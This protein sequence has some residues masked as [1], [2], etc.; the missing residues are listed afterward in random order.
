MRTHIVRLRAVLLGGSVVL[1][2]GFLLWKTRT[3]DTDAHGRFTDDLRQLKQ[4]D[5]NLN[6]DLLKI[7][8]GLLANYDSITDTLDKLKITQER[9]AQLPSFLH[10]H[11]RNEI[12]DLLT[13]YA[14]AL[15]DKEGIIERLKT[16]SA[17]LKNSLDYLPKLVQETA[18]KSAETPT[19]SE[20]PPL[21]NE[22]LQNILLYN[23]NGNDQLVTAISAHMETLTQNRDRYAKALQGPAIARIVAHVQA[24][25]KYKPQVDTLLQE[26]I[27]LP[28]AQR[29]DE[30]T[31]T[32][33]KQYEQVLG[34]ANRYRYALYSAIFSLL[35]YVAYTFLRVQ[36]MANALR[37]SEDRMTRVMSATDDGIWDWALQTNAV[38]YSPRFKAQ[39]GYEDHELPNLLSSFDSHLHP[40]DKERVQHALK[41]HC[42]HR[43]PYHLEFRLRTR[44]NEYIWIDAYG[45]AAWDD[46]G[47]PVRMSGTHRDISVQKHTEEQ[48]RTSAALLA[49]STTQIMTTVQQL[50]TSTT[51]TASAIAETAATMEEVRQTATIAGEQAKEVATNTAQ[52]SEITRSGE[53]A[54]EQAIAGLRQTRTQMESIAQS[55]VTLGEQSKTVSDIINVV[56]EIAEQSNLLAVNAAIE[57]AKAGE[58]GKG[59]AVVA[60]EVKHL[61]RQSK[62]ATDQVQAIL[63]D[64]QK[65]ANIAVLVTEQGT[66]AVEV[67]VTQSIEANQSIHVLTKSIVDTTESVTRIA[68]SSQQQIVGIDQAASAMASV[69]EAS[70]QNL[71]NIRN[72]HTAVQ[73]LHTVGQT[74]Q[75][76]V[77]H[78]TS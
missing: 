42:E 55:V 36:Q 8:N 43:A 9:L 47:T 52:T 48:L 50:V 53:H 54:V 25:L 20:L 71:D 45:Q 28:T 77:E 69:K 26:A 31:E 18:K 46:Q 41:E 29:V 1:F 38:Y 49:T 73:Q 39:L 72:I 65:A 19:I 74:L 16:S 67:G 44:K 32:Y 15:T 51:Q 59:F 35:V 64:I 23:L 7:R 63:H 34:A 68:A 12:G 62:Q 30:L 22:T 57:A 40:D 24:I 60:Q 75:Q 11:D 17:T 21:L 2:L 78:Y 56:N 37:V 27:G 6:Q 13:S 10:E 58:Q 70:T 4:L 76:L 5:I 66:R 3:I 14:Q 61:A 33:T